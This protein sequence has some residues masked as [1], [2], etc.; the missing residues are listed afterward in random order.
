MRAFLPLLLVSTLIIVIPRTGSA[1]LSKVEVFDGGINQ[2][3]EATMKAVKRNWKKVKSADRNA[4]EIRFHTG[5]SPA[6]WGEGCTVNLR[7]LGDG[8]VEVSLKLRN[9]AQLYAWGGQDRP[10]TIQVNSG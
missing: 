2:V 8:K 4:G 9:S 3:F 5:V 1:G 6:S 7:D 10:K